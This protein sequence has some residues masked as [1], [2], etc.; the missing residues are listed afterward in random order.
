MSGTKLSSPWGQLLDLLALSSP[1]LTNEMAMVPLNAYWRT[2]LQG[3]PE[4][5]MGY[6][7]AWVRLLDGRTFDEVV[8]LDG[9]IQ[10][11][12][13][14]SEVPFFDAGDIAEIKVRNGLLLTK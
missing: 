7:I 4:T 8:I 14:S 11:V 10:E 9:A 5:G 1:P 13:G 6:Q 12:A 2:Y 3:Q